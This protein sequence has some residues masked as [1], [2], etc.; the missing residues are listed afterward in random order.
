[1]D[2]FIELCRERSEE[3]GLYAIAYAIMVSANERKKNNEFRLP[4]DIDEDVAKRI[5]V[6]LDAKK[7]KSF[8][9]LD[10]WT[11]CLGREV[12]EYDRTNAKLLGR[13]IGLLNNL[14]DAGI[15]KSSHYGKQRIYYV[16]HKDTA[17]TAPADDDDL[18]I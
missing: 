9:L 8:C 12:A 5:S 7:V 3:D 6:W 4:E 11:E 17:P 14:V 13:A 1:M 2:A 16:V 18:G 10:A 15:R